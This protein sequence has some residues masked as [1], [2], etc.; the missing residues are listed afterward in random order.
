MHISGIQQIGIGTTDLY[1]SWKW[2][3]E[4]FGTNI[5]ILEDNTVAERMLRYTGN[6]PQKRHAAITI[7]MQGG[8]GFEIWQYSEREP[9]KIEFEIQIGDLGIY[10]AKVKSRNVKLFHKEVSKKYANIS[11]IFYTPDNLPTLYIY[12]PFG[13]YF[14]VVEDSSLFSDCKRNNGGGIGAQIGVSNIEKAL[15]LYRD[16][17]GYDTLVYDKTGVFEDFVFMHGG[18]Q[19]YRR[20]LLKHS[21]KR[22]GAFS[23]LF[24]PSLIEL[25]VAL[26]REP[27][28]IYEGRYWGDPGFIHLCFDI[29][30]MKAFKQLCEEKGF[31]FTVDS[32]PTG[33]TFDMGDAAGHFTYVEDPD[34]TLIEFVE[35]HKIPIL[36]KLNLYINLKKRDQTKPLPK[37]MLKALG[38]NKVK[39]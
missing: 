32:C 16:V 13:N 18:E 22:E 1:E 14:Q 6:S 4:F 38:L 9:K 15:T 10:C 27:K 2:Y 37:I 34:G 23:E 29:T 17:L 25:V 11:P 30:N 7:N 21:E 26:E 24:G 8:S 28:K 12:D 20:V 35:T 33:E 36:K 3:A 19:K 31:P 39:F 5:R